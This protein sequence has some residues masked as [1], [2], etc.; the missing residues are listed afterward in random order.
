MKSCLKQN[1]KFSQFLSYF[2]KIHFRREKFKQVKPFNL[3]FCL[4][5][6]KTI[7]QNVHPIQKGIAFMFE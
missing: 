7:M 1:L 2:L 4:Q 6:F 5:K 3:N